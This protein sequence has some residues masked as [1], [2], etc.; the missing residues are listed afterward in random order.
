MARLFNTGQRFWAT[1]EGD[2]VWLHHRFS[3][4][5]REGRRQVSE[6][7]LMLWIELIRL[8]AGAGWRPTQIR[9]E[10]VRPRYSR[11]L[12]ALAAEDVRFEQ[13]ATALAIPR[14]LLSLP[15]P[16]LAVDRT[17]P[18]AP[19]ASGPLPDLDFTGSARQA[20]AALLLIGSPHIEAAARAAGTSVRS[21]QRH[22]ATAHLSFFAAARGGPLR[23]RA[24][25][26][27]RSEHEGDRDLR[28]ARLHGLG[29]LHARLPALDRALAAGVPPLS[30][31]L[32][33][34]A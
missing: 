11:A 23:R 33:S 17:S 5:L 19:A 1:R 12:E 10:G 24:A 14:S 32:R 9:L 25:H 30:S 27:A 29:E 6:F 20:V 18:L 16:A 13:P 15:L 21:L 7:T 31:R 2:D 3:P 28:R 4:V 8:V 26:A 22:L 34:D